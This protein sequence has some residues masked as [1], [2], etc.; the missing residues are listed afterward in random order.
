MSVRRLPLPL[1]LAL[2]GC[3]A[4]PASVQSEVVTGDGLVRLRFATEG[5]NGFVAAGRSCEAQE[6]GACAIEI[7][8]ADLQAGWNQ[9]DVQTRRRTGED[10][11][12]RAAF[13]LGD[14]SFRRECSVTG[15]GDPADP[16]AY[17]FDLA[18][19]FEEGFHGELAGKPLRE[20]RATIRAGDLDLS[21][22][23]GGVDRPLARVD[24]PLAVVNRVGA[25]WPR[26]VPAVVPLPLV[27]LAIEGAYSPWYE[28]VLTLRL[29]AEPGARVSVGGR[30][31]GWP[32]SDGWVRHDVPIASGPN[33]IHVEA[34][35]DGKV[36][37]V[38]D[39]EV[40]GAAPGTPL[41]LDEPASTEV[42]S[43]LPE[44]RVRGSTSPQAKLYV[45]RRPI[46]HGPDGSFDLLIPLLEGENEVEIM[47]VV[48]PAPGVASRPPTSR[49]VAARH[50]RR[51]A[52]AAQQFLAQIPAGEMAQTLAGLAEDPWAMTSRKVRFPMVV[53]ESSKALAPSGCTARISGL[54]CTMETTSPVMVA[55]ERRIARGCTGDEIPVVVELPSCPAL[56]TGDR[57]EVLGTVMGGLG[58]RH[59]QLTALRPRIS[60]ALVEAAPF[61]VPAG[62]EGP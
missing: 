34:T 18:C 8:T 28:D 24:L 3:A 39:I 62:G 37:A 53:G 60:G 1:V 61:L 16:Q 20:D 9:L 13:F 15:I 17:A 44:L 23:E 36:A 33:A 29:R 51:P 52:M 35:R 12:L 14:D 4:G 48:D 47:A 7:P 31:V 43:V 32:D 27:Q 38:H 2:A 19:R 54:A 26:P 5:R 50:V 40:I 21:G 42:V 45:G 56:G 10:G 6:G 41:Y 55:F 49:T 22:F 11:P 46:E 25:R 58:G 30:Q 57:I 59:G